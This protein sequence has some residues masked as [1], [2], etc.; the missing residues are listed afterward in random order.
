LPAITHIRMSADPSRIASL[1]SEG[2]AI[3]A[4]R[5]AI[6]AATPSEPAAAAPAPTANLTRIASLK[7]EGE[8]V[9]AR[10]AAIVAATPAEPAAAPAPTASPDRIALLRS[11][12]ERVV[13]RRA[14]VAAAPPS[15]F[16]I[17][18]SGLPAV[19]M[20]DEAQAETE[21]E[22]VTEA[23]AEAV[24]EAEE[25]GDDEAE[26]VAPDFVDRAE[27]RVAARAAAREAEATGTVSPPPPADA[28]PATEAVPDTTAPVLVPDPPVGVLARNSITLPPAVSEALESA[29]LFDPTKLQAQEQDDWLGVVGFGT[30]L[31][32]L[33]PIF[34]AGL[35]P[36]ILFSALFGGGLAAYVGL[37]KDEAGTISRTT[38]R[39]ANKAALTT[40][41]KAVDIEEE[42]E[43]SRKVREK[44]VETVKGVTEELRKKL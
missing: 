14:A 9:V 26:A 22:A 31:A 17:P 19:A 42:Y 40:Y 13:A 10:R 35:I 21:A 32:F 8:A 23:E 34:E 43:V 28:Q 30:V 41:K 1:K 3:V 44:A 4:R 15:M 7:N 27:Q 12:G 6:A 36:D 16:T 33:L 11:Q 25:M 39:L 24:D 38:G 18:D 37:R 29:D 5:A 2:E 20:E